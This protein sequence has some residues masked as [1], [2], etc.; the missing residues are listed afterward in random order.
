[1]I[2]S[3]LKQ[4][5]TEETS[6]QTDEIPGHQLETIE[7][8]SSATNEP[9]NSFNN[10]KTK[11]VECSNTSSLHSLRNSEAVNN[12]QEKEAGWNTEEKKGQKSLAEQVKEAAQSAMQQSGMVYVDTVGMYYDYKTGYYYNSVSFF[13]YLQVQCCSK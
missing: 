1:M 2:Y 5:T 13:Y 9:L 6:T 3:Q 12:E 11:D 4:I 7:K 8:E 10:A